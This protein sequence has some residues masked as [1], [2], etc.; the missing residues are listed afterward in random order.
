[1]Q[2]VAISKFKAKC[3]ALV[4]KVRKTKRPLRVTRRGKPVAD[5]IPVFSRSEANWLGSMADA[6][7]ICG[8]IVSPVIGEIDFS[9]LH[10]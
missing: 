7:E 10:E 3:F 5:L 8:D 1:M 2:E 6:M 9:A 4:E